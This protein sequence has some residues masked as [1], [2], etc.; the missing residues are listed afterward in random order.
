MM[1]THLSSTASI[2]RNSI[3]ML[4]WSNIIAYT[5]AKGLYWIVMVLA[6]SSTDRC[7]QCTATDRCIQCTATYRCIQC[8]ATDRCIQCTATYICMQCTATD[9][10]IQYTATYRCI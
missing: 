6:V 2:V 4:Q 8:T 1:R 3:I 10:C 9:R 7:I 5:V